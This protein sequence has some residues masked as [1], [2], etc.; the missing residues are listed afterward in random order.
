MRLGED[1]GADAPDERR[2]H[3][4]RRRHECRELGV[5]KAKGASLARLGSGLVDH[6]E[7]GPGD[8]IPIVRQM[9]RNDGLDLEDELRDVA[10]PEIEGGHNRDVDCI[11]QG[12]PRLLGDLLQARR[13]WLFL[14]AR[15]R[16]RGEKGQRREHSSKTP[17][18]APGASRSHRRSARCAASPVAA[19]GPSA[20]ADVRHS[21]RPLATEPVPGA[22]P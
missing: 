3:R 19:S 12:V 16:R 13:R 4:V 1:D 9:K 5:A 11:R 17:H 22:G 6:R 10:R 7:I 8:Q 2:R 15:A 18:R 20:G 21:V 14:R